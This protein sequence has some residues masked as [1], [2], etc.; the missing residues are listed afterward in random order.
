MNVEPYASAFRRA[1]LSLRRA[2]AFVAI[3]VSSLGIALGISTTVLAHIDSLTHPYVP[4]RDAERPYHVWVAGDGAISNPTGS[5]I[6]DM[7]QQMSSF[8]G[9]VGPEAR[10]ATIEVGTMGGQAFAAAVPT[11]YFDLLGITPRLGRRFTANETDASGVAIVSDKLWRTLFQNRDSIGSSVLTF[12]G[13]QYSVVGVM[14]RGLERIDRPDLF[15]PTPSRLSRYTFFLARLKSNATDGRARTEGKVVADRIA[16]TYGVGRRSW[17]F[18]M[19]SAKPDPLQLQA[20]H[21]AMIGAAICILVI[22]CANVAALMLA[23]GVTKRRDQ[24]LR[25]AL[26][27]SGRDL[28]VDVAAE[29]SVLALAGAAFGVLLASWIMHIVS[30]IVPEQLAALGIGDPRWSWRVF[31]ESL[32]AVLTAIGLA[33]ALPAWYATKVSPNEPLK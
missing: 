13:K 15:F 10:Y 17:T 32:L 26:G 28:M 30:G 19:L 1:A 33:A 20:Y 31:A 23:R 8:E 6:R 18:M 22:A 3:A 24:S 29:V 21:G 16:S 11:N 14:P 7:L 27:A 9:V 12:A 4:V 5:D 25:L 2:P